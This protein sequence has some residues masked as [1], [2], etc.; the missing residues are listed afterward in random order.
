MDETPLA[1]LTVLDL[2]QGLAGPTA[3]ALLGDFGAEVVSVEP[4]GGASQRSLVDGTMFPNVARNKRSIVLDL[5]AE[6]GTAVFHRLLAD[7]DVLIHNNRPPV[8]ERL[9]TDYETVSA[10]EPELVYCSI[11]G[12]GESGPYSDR[13]GIDPLAQAMSGLMWMTGEPDRKPSRVGA[14]TIDVGTGV[15]A[16]FAMFPAVRHAER[17]G[18]GQK[19]EASLLDTAAAFV[20]TWYTYYSKLGDVPGRQGH[21]WDAYAPAGVVE[22]ATGLLYLATPFDHLWERL[23]RAVDREDWLED[24]RFA[25]DDDRLANREALFAELDDEF[26]TLDRETAIRRLLAAGVP[27]AEVRTVPEAAADEQLCE[28]GTVRRIED[29]DGNDRFAT[30]SPLTLSET[31]P[32]VRRPLPGLG[33]HTRAILRHL[34]YDESAIEALHE[35]GVVDST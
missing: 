4:P 34:G 22:T 8:A 12:Y 17:T 10:L 16:A 3:A 1:D 15:Y 6:R 19:V 9:G 14:P 18:E 21:T 13:P 23:C 25:T 26:R 7:A 24:P 27:A 30:V 5:R 31:D 2:S 33:E 11:T 29:A 28:R 35:T 32:T 20:G